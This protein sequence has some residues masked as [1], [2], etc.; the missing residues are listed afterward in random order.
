MN[1]NVRVVGS[2]PVDPNPILWVSEDFQSLGQS[3]DYFPMPGTYSATSDY[4]SNVMLTFNVIYGHD[5]TDPKA[6]DEKKCSKTMTLPKSAVYA[7][8]VSL[9]MFGLLGLGNLIMDRLDNNEKKGK[10]HSPSVGDEGMGGDITDYA[11]QRSKE[12]ISV[13]ATP[14]AKSPSDAH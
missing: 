4:N 8:Q 7:A 6:N 1:H 10:N 11:L 12:R 2:S 3:V 5:S 14:A 13:A 9:F